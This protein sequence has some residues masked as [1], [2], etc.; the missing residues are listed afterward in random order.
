[1]VKLASDADEF[2]AGASPLEKAETGSP[3]DFVNRMMTVLPARW[4]PDTAP[5]LT[6]VLS[7][8]ASVWAALYALL[9]FVRQQA[10]IGTASGVFLDMVARDFFGTALE[11]GGL[12]D[13]SFRVAILRRILRQGGTRAGLSAELT[14]LTGTAPTLIEGA[15]PADCGTWNGG[16][17]AIGYDQAGTWGTLQPMQVF[18][19]TAAGT[20]ASSDITATATDMAPCGA[21]VGLRITS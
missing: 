4:F 12:S 2:I 3:A 15:R 10:R 1:M 20:A 5:V 11:R 19:T 6:G 21:T 18:V 7:G 13:A 14:A 8:I 16:L 17:V 9:M